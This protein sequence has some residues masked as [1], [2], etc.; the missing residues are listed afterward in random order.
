[1]GTP[2][3]E[4]FSSSLPGKREKPYMTKVLFS[5]VRH[6][7]AHFTDGPFINNSQKDANK[8]KITSYPNFLDLCSNMIIIVVFI[9]FLNMESDCTLHVVV[10]TV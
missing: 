8:Y 10:V 5:K 1:M 7:K 9:M 3:H 4:L 2:Q 6:T